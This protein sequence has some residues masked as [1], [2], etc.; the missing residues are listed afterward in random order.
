MM[1]DHGFCA[2]V[3]LVIFMEKR[4]AIILNGLNMIDLIEIDD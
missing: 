3:K 1:F 2:K 4:A